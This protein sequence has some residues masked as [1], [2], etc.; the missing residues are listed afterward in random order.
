[1]QHNPKFEIF[2]LIPTHF[3]IKTGRF[4]MIV[5][6]QVL[7]KPVFRQQK[8]EAKRV[9][10]RHRDRKGQTSPRDNMNKEIALRNIELCTRVKFI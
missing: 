1:M 5:N 9:K 4:A 6:N 8:E 2:E 7:I 3:L 10:Q